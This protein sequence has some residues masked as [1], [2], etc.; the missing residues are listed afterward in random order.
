MKLSP[1]FV[2]SAEEVD[3]LI[4][5]FPFALVISAE[6]SMVHAT[7]LPLVLER[8]ADGVTYLIGHFARANPQVEALRRQP[9]A[10]AAFMGV[11]S[12]ISPSWIA[13]RTQAPTW[14]Y[15]TAHLQ[16]EVVFGDGPEETAEALNALTA[17]V[18]AGR[19]NAWNASEMGERYAGMSRAIIPFRARV[20]AVHAKFK[21]GQNERQD[22]FE[23]VVVGLERNGESNL[24]QAMKRERERLST[25]KRQPS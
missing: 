25:V 20:S 14:N 18:E 19:P 12:Y 5:E 21:L 16:L 2:P 22:V 6:N 23:D 10:I 13:D 17:V 3:R 1:L 15:E 8:E 7:P 11:N 4:R 24:A 9:V